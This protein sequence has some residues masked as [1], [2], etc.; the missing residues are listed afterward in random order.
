MYSSVLREAFITSLAALDSRGGCHNIIA[1]P[2]PLECLYTIIVVVRCIERARLSLLRR[3]PRAYT[4]P[5]ISRKLIYTTDTIVYINYRS[6]GIALW[7]EGRI[8][9][10]QSGLRRIWIVH[11]WKP[12]SLVVRGDFRILRWNIKNITTSETYANVFFA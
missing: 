11:C 3:G 12:N 9:C 6:V 10:D 5:E 4:H 7:G 8:A 2:S 1:S